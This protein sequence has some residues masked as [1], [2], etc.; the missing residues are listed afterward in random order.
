M[1]VSWLFEV[2]SYKWSTKKVVYSTA[3]Y[4]AKVLPE[5]FSGIT[6]RW[7]VGRRGLITPSDLSFEIDNADGAVSAATLEGQ[8]C[9]IIMI[10][11]GAESRRW[12]FR[13]QAATGFYGK[14]VVDCVDIL[15]AVLIGDYPNTPQPREIFPSEMHVV[16]EDDTARMPVIFGKAFIPLMLVYRQIDSTA[17]YALGQVDTYTISKVMDPPTMGQ[18]LWTSAEYTFNQYTDSGY[19]LAEFIVHYDPET[20]S[21]SAGTWSS[22]N[23]PLV[24]YKVTGDADTVNP[25]DMLDYILRSFGLSTSDIDA[26]TWGAAHTTYTSWGLAWQGG[27]W[28]AEARETILNNLLKQCDSNLYISDKVELLPF[29][30]TS[31]ETFTSSKTKLLSFSVTNVPRETYDSGR[32][33]WVNPGSPQS[34]LSGKAIVPATT[35]GTTA[36]PSGD[37]FEAPFVSSGIVAQKLGMLHFQRQR[38]GT[39]VS[40]STVGSKMTS[41]A[42]LKPGQVITVNDALFGGSTGLIVTSL[43]INPDLGVSIEGVKLEEINEF[44]DVSASDVTIGSIPTPSF[45]ASAKLL[46]LRSSGQIFHFDSAGDPDPVVQTLT[47]KVYEQNLAAGNYVFTTTPNIK[48]QTSSSNTFT[49]TN[50]EFGASDNVLVSVS[51]TNNPATMTDSVTV[52]RVRDGLD[53]SAME[54][55]LDIQG[56]M[57]DGGFSATSAAVVGWTSGTITFS[58]GSN[59]LAASFDLVAGS[60][61]TMLGKSY[62]YFDQTTSETE[63]LV[64]TTPQASV[65]RN[66][67]LIAIA[68]PGTTAPAFFVFG[69]NGG[70]LISETQIGDNSISTGKV[71]A[72]AI[73]ANEIAANTITGN[74]ILANSISAT[75]I[76][77][78][79]ITIGSFSGAGNLAGLDLIESAQLGSTI[80]SG[81]YIKS[82]LLDVDAILTDVLFVGDVGDLAGLDLIE[83]AQLGSTIISGGYI[84]ADLIDVVN[85]TVGDTL[86]VGGTLAATVRDDASY[87]ASTADDALAAAEAAAVT[88]TWETVSGTGKPADNADVTGANTAY[89]TARVAGTVAA[90][91]RD[92]ANDA[93]TAAASAYNLAASKVA[94]SEVAAAINNNTTTING[95]K[96]TT[97]TI[98]ASAISLSPAD[99]SGYVGGGTLAFTSSGKV[100]FASST[101]HISGSS[102]GI[103]IYTPSA[104]LSLGSGFFLCDTTHD[105]RLNA[106]GSGSDV[107]LDCGAYVTD[108]HGIINFRTNGTSRMFLK[109]NSPGLYPR[110]NNNMYLGYSGNLWKAIYGYA[111]YDEN[112][113]FQD[114]L[115]DLYE[116]S[117]F[118]PRY[119]TEVDPLTEKSIP[120]RDSKTGEKVL[121]RCPKTD[122]M[123]LDNHS[124]PKWLNNYDECA[125]KLRDDCGSMVT[126]EDIIYLLSVHGEAGWLI[127]RNI[128]LF[129]DLT[130]GAVRQQNTESLAMYEL[131]ASRLTALEQQNVSLQQ[132][133]DALKAAKEI[134]H[135]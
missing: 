13:I 134:K 77:T 88:A 57:F 86:Y 130:S 72:N 116:L 25:S 39:R 126:E 59:S 12:R 66:Q 46:Q 16:E 110:Y 104:G 90:T 19:S 50:T 63:L 34:E 107:I 22:A 24:E 55:T 111:F 113:L 119:K 95:S 118:K 2:G 105:I 70:L 76:D 37:V 123:L 35:G 9:T 129:V 80:I 45:S 11:D 89:D 81:G 91:I 127:G 71:Q 61:G 102:G 131:L 43:S 10:I 32:V 120:K 4:T 36:T 30:K 60:T 78:G 27:F 6:M 47:F 68:E 18:T 31:R 96:I 69:G 94:A 3:T 121:D 135:I 98:N 67:V 33:H 15:Q 49:L 93:I 1:I 73:T 101:N 82:T 51:K 54:Q 106:T 8:D 23:E 109:D 7:D 41:L 97:G 83:S 125:Q 103:S 79:S 53:A 100:T 85:M 44:N 28:Q 58:G 114:E 52:V 5:S 48:A 65:G 40:F 87:G 56:W 122:M 62:I 38:I 42:T 14:I 124:L 133:I 112:G 84:K 29:S 115:D 92:N 74:E 99:V 26:T 128:A 132:Q 117:Q 17:Y 21:Y 20:D 64:T 108:Y 75:E